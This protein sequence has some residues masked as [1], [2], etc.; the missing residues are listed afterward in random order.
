[1]VYSDTSTKQGII[2][3][4]ESIIFSSNY[5]TISGDTTLLQTFTRYV[6]QA[7][8]V[9][10]IKLLESDDRWQFDDSNYTDLQIGVSNLVNG[11]Q[12]YRILVTHLKILGV[13]VLDT[14]GK[15][16]KLHQFDP[17]DVGQDRQTFMDEPSMPVWYDLQG[18]SIFL[19]PAPAT[20][21]VTLTG[22]LKVYFQR[23]LQYFAT[24]DTTKTPGFPSTFHRLVALW[25]S[26]FYCQANSI[27]DK[28]A[29]LAFEI[30]RYEDDMQGFMTRRNKDSRTRLTPAR[31]QSL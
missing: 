4:I 27:G 16:Y 28:L 3:E 10:T 22:G 17:V 20:G 14:S 24:S 1:M 15:F 26:Y 2:Q 13:S 25:A 18:N 21:S 8:D 6:N 31:V 11:Q 30:K 23:P 19:Y 9:V 29:T 7:L 5:G 12:D